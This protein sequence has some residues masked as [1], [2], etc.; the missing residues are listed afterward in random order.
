MWRPRIMPG[1][2]GICQ[3]S[4]STCLAVTS[5]ADLADTI[6]GGNGWNLWV[7]QGWEEDEIR[8]ESLLLQR[9]SHTG[10]EKNHLPLLS[11]LATGVALWERRSARPLSLESMVRVAGSLAAEADP[12]RWGRYADR[13]EVGVALWEC[14]KN[15]NSQAPPQTFS[16]YFTCKMETLYSVW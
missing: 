9:T 10:W 3:P 7:G 6:R 8:T 11:L 2:W 13:C 14:V 12:P 16:N 15:A 1:F 4:N 5:R